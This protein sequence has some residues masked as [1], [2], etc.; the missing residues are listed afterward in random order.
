MESM[1][2][3]LNLISLVELI[4]MLM[5]SLALAGITGRL[6]LSPLA[7]IVSVINRSRPGT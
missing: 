3:L 6:V 7:A 1:R 2:A 5:L 4:L